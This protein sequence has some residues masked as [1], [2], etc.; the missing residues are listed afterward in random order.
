M[1]STAGHAIVTGGT[2]GIGQA[3]CVQLAT[4]GYQLTVIGRSEARLDETRQLLAEVSGATT[5]HLYVRA[6][7]TDAEQLRDMAEQS[8]ARFGSIDVMISSAGIGRSA[9]SA[10]V[11]P[12]ATADLPLTE[13]NAVLDVNLRGVFLCCAA[14][15]P[16]MQ[17]Q[18]SGHIVN[19]GSSTTPEGLR[20][21]AY[22]PA[23]CAS[24]FGVVGLTEA[25]AAENERYGIRAQVVFPGPV[26][27]PL[28]HQTVLSRP[29]GGSVSATNFAAAVVSLIRQPAD[30]VVIHPHLLPFRGA[31]DSLARQSELN[32]L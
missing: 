2:S 32:R 12:H 11:I 27:T 9:E 16:F 23:Y 29:F 26:E 19:I 1:S 20:G 13:W 18:H 5:E 8:Q 6:D 30:G 22:G 4:Q 28:V 10:R 7:V 24:K 3:L 17:K 31:P 14:V 21:T 15:L 25:V